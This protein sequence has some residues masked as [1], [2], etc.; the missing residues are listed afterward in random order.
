M[1]ILG[2]PFFTIFFTISFLLLLIRY[3]KLLKNIPLSY[4]ISLIS[5]RSIALIILL[6]LL[7]N[8][9]A[10]FKKKDQIPQNIDVIFD[11]SESMY[12]H[13][14]KMELSIEGIMQ[15]FNTL[16]GNNQVDKNFYRLGKEIQFINDNIVAIGVTDF[17]NLSNFMVFEN[18][19]QILLITD[20]KATVGRELNNI[21]FPKNIPI[22]AIGV[23]PVNSE[24]DLAIDRVIIPHLSDITDTV[25]LL[26]KISTKIQNDAV[27]RLDINNGNGEKIFTKSVSLKSGA[28][29]HEMEIFIPAINFSGLN[30]VTIHSINGESQLKNNQYAFKVNVKSDIDKVV[31]I[32]GALSTNTSSIKS[33]LNLLE[34]IEVNHYYRI[35]ALNWNINPESVLSKNHK[36]I[37]FDD[38]PT[39]NNDRILFD[40]LIQSSRSQHIPIVYLEGPKS[41]LITGEIIRSHFP[42]FIPS[43][44]DSEILT[45]L[46]D[47]YS[48]I[49][50]FKLSSFPP[51]ARSVKWTIDNNN[52]INFT[53]GSFM[54]ANKNDVYMVAIPDITGNHLKTKNNLSSPIFNLLNKLFLHAYFGNEGLLAMHIDGSSFKKGE[55]FS[56]KLV[57]VENL[58]LSNFKV[59]VIDSNLDTVTTDCIKSFPEKYYNCNLTLHSPGEF[60][61]RGE[62]KLPDGKKINSTN[63]S[64]IVQD[65]NIE[66][67]ELIQEQNILMQVAHTSGG[68]Y[69]PI[70]SLDSMFSNIEITPIHNLRNYQISGLSTQNYWWLVIILL[71]AEW[72]IRKKLGLL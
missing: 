40:K 51:Q 22:H 53:D 6:L 61:L 64:I 52:W 24:N 54:V 17:T 57:P 37:V 18:P 35:D 11:L 44:I 56:A 55:I 34:G 5:L 19:N 66:L 38:F 7:I 30:N 69:I 59:K 14:D 50:K 23:G 1:K 8:P 21:N 31:M 10:N 15:S 12:A 42:F 60:T 41:S 62:A 28:H 43:T 39:G 65:I 32:T 47:E 3:W 13:F 25:K 45:S 58:G 27:T 49:I 67:E 68:I 72:F 16:F 9:W 26:M 46:S 2:S 71:S 4:K 63:K 70:E 20:G 48:K 36:L 29:N 33:I